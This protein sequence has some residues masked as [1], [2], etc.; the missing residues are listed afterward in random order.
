MKLSHGSANLLFLILAVPT[1]VFA[2]DLDCDVIV[3]ASQIQTQD[4][5]V[6]QDMES[7]FE[8]FLNNRDWTP[9][10]FNPEERI[11]CSLSI[12]LVDMPEIGQFRATVQVRSA[13]PIYDSN[14]ESIIFNFAD[15]DWRFT[16]IESMPLIFNEN[17][18]TSN[19]TSMLAFYAYVIL[20]LDYDSFG[21]LSGSLFFQQAQNI[22]TQAAQSNRPGWSGLESTRNRYAL[23]DDITNQR[24]E[25]IRQGYYR[26]HRLGLDIFGEDPDQARKEIIGMLESMKAVKA[27]YPASIFVI[28][29]FDAKARELV[30]IFS[31]GSIA[32]K[33]NAYNLLM[34]LNPS[35]GDTY[36]RI[37]N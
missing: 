27:Q 30:D 6:F 25:S 36:A 21:E 13:R 14:Y 37:I 19:I 12:S 28:S 5:H 7:A 23:I 17:A 26:Y 10:E 22:V 34:E 33:R 20:G 31:D 15:R 11:K 18:F 9:D 8:D 3:D 32:D 16:Y 24:M 35:K 29:F 1:I 2:Q 4:R